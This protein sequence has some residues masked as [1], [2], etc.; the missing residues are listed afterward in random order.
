MLRSASCVR[1]DSVKDGS[2][3]DINPFIDAEI[4][5]ACGEGDREVWFLL[6]SSSEGVEDEEAT[7]VSER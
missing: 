1:G 3:L 5:D 4:V 2:R 6:S 7:E